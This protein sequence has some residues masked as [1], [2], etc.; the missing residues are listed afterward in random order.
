MQS[1]FHG[2]ECGSAANSY[3]QYLMGNERKLSK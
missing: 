3:R 2:K 1:V